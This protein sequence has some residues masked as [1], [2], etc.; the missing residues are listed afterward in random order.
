MSSKLWI[1][2][3]LLLRTAYSNAAKSRGHG[4]LRRRRRYGL[5]VDHPRAHGCR[6]P[7]DLLKDL[8]NLA[9]IL[10][11]QSDDMMGEHEGWTEESHLQ[12]GLAGQ[13]DRIETSI[14]LEP[15]L[16]P[17]QIAGTKCALA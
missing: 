13:R 3:Q 6:V 5:L 9:A 15:R 7:V 4:L 17:K 14:H 1:D 12:G 2:P 11:A 16:T 8:D 10:H